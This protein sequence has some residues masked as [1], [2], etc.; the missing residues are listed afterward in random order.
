M[1]GIGECRN[2]LY[3]LIDDNLEMAI[4]KISELV[5]RKACDRKQL[6]A[7]QTIN[8]ENGIL[9]TEPLSETS[10]WHHR[11]GHTPLKKS[12]QIGCVR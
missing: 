7:L 5:R 9:Q 11:L 12:K 6:I 4:K 8:T 2:G 1:R 10:L 3:D